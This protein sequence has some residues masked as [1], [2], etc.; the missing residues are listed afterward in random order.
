MGLY[1]ENSTSG[2]SVTPYNLGTDESILVGSAGVVYSTGSNAIFGNSAN[3]S[4]Y[5][6]GTVLASVSDGI[7]F[8]LDGQQ[9]GIRVTIAES[10]YIQAGNIG[11]NAYGSGV[12]VVNMGSINASLGIAIGSI[13]GSTCTVTNTGTITGSTS[14]VGNRGTGGIHLVNEGKIVAEYSFYGSGGVDLIENA[15]VMRGA[16]ILGAGNDIYRGAEGRLV[17]GIEGGLG[18]DTIIGGNNDDTVLGGLGNDRLEGRGGADDF[19]FNTALNGSTNVD[20][21]IGLS[22]LDHI[23]LENAVFTALG[24]TFISNEFR[25]IG[26]GTSFAAVDASDRIIYLKSTGDLYYDADGSGTAHSRIKF[27]DMVA[28]TT[29]HFANFEL[30]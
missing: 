25:S 27:I 12:R 11:V 21:I 20:K 14:G 23:Q 24:K 5:I 10:G 30:I 19:V 1:V 3:Q 26:S 2:G 15:G 18:K 22:S 28:N 16:I 7:H 17:G 8:G 9:A 4:A 6:S 29:L 13:D